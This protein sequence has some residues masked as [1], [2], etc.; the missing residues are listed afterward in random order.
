MSDLS[1]M[2]PKR[3]CCLRPIGIAGNACEFNIEFGHSSHTG[4]QFVDIATDAS[5]REGEV[6]HY[7]NRIGRSRIVHCPYAALLLLAF[8]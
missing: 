1:Q 5:A 4:E 8:E 3:I 7:P 2:G 6:V